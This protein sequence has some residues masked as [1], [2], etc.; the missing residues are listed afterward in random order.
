MKHHPTTTFILAASLLSLLPF[1]PARAEDPVVPADEFVKAFSVSDEEMNRLISIEAPPTVA[2][3]VH[4][5]TDSA[6]IKGSHNLSQLEQL[7]KAL[8]SAALS[9]RVFSVEGH[10][11]K[12]GEA[13]YNLK[14]SQRR[15]QAVADYLVEKHGVDPKQLQVNGQGEYFLLDEGDNDEAHAKNRRVEIVLNGNKE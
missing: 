11:D 15:S 1:L 3:K 6:E 9:K 13:A 5:D 7:G 12:R 4:F 8:A 10:T 2:I 14:L